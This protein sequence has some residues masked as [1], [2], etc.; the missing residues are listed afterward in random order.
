MKTIDAEKEFARL[1]RPLLI[2]MIL[3]LRAKVAELQGGGITIK[4]WWCNCDAFNGEEHSPRTTCRHC[5][6]EK[7]AAAYVESAVN[8]ST[9]KKEGI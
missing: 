3:V 7:H 5:G 2:A 4:G 8:T 1:G 6:K 9:E